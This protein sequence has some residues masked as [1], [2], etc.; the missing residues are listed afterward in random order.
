M[1]NHQNIERENLFKELSVV[2]KNDNNLFRYRFDTK[3]LNSAL[4]LNNKFLYPD[5]AV[6][7][8][9][10]FAD[11]SDFNSDTD[12]KIIYFDDEN[13][14]SLNPLNDTELEILRSILIVAVLV[15]KLLII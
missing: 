15:K 4:Q 9:Y 13:L 3:R 12:D 8:N 1:L 11:I 5:H 2:G 6:F 14:L 10:S 7:G